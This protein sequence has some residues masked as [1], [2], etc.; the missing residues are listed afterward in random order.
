MEH[1]LLGEKGG[2]SSM[3]QLGRE[4]AKH[5]MSENPKEEWES[6]L[7][8]ALTEFGFARIEKSIHMTVFLRDIR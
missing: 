2:F 1:K 7:E 5:L 4:I 8:N 3:R 6:I